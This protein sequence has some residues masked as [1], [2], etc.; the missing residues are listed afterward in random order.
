MKAVGIL[1]KHFQTIKET[2]FSTW[3]DYH[4]KETSQKISMMI[5]LF[6]LEEEAKVNAR[7]DEDSDEEAKTAMA[8]PFD[9]DVVDCGIGSERRREIENL[10]VV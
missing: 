2:C 8:S 5:C 6:V 7:Q 9:D 4:P 3:T 10:F 1:L